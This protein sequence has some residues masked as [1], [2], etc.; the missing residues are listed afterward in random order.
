MRVLVCEDEE[1]MAE[2]VRQAL[3]EEGLEVDVVRTGE[4]AVDAARGASYDL[5]LLDVMLPGLDGFATCRRLRERGS[6]VPV[7]MLTARGDVD[8][9][10]AGLDA[11]ADDYLPKPFSLAEL[12][13]RVRALLRRGPASFGSR[14][15]VGELE[16]DLA[17]ATLR[18]RGV[19]VELAPRELAVLEQLMRRPGQVVTRELLLDRAW[20]ETSQTQSN[21]L[22]AVVRRLREKV[23]RPFGSSSI[24][25][26]RGAGYRLAAS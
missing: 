24:E 3:A 19:R 4:R 16:L 21:V 8:D 26:V 7:L 14:I 23:D 1:L 10:V 17:A 20:P 25:T 11:G 6:G 9:R 15:A 13:A 2:L 22:E 18:R 12:L 5:V